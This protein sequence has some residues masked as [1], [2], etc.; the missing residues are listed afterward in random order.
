LQQCCH[1][2]FKY[3][4]Y[5]AS[6][7][8]LEDSDKEQLL[9]IIYEQIST[10]L[11]RTR[12]RLQEAIAN[13]TNIERVDKEFQSF[14]ALCAQ[15]SAEDT[16]DISFW[17]GLDPELRYI[18]HSEGI[19]RYDPF[20]PVYFPGTI[21]RDYLAQQVKGKN[22]TSAVQSIAATSE[23][24]HWLHIHRPD[25]ETKHIG[26]SKLEYRLLK[27][28]LQHADYCTEQELIQSAWENGTERANLTQRLHKLRKKLEEQLDGAGIIENRY[29]GIYS[30]THIDWL[31]LD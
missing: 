12:K 15:K 11:S 7:W 31:E 16:L 19:V 30:M 13:S 17:D 3:K 6:K 10:F 27:T 23:H 25:M 20:R 14:I 5:L 4:T 26:L 18:L 8:R 22:K 21:L 24:G 28:L 9:S 1:Y 2:L 29:G